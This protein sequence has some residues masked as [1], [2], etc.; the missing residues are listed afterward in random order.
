[1]QRVLIVFILL[2]ILSLKSKTQEKN[3]IIQFNGSAS[4]TD[5]FYSS[6]GIDPR[7]PSNILMTILRANIT[8]FGQIELPFELY[9]SNQRIKFQ[10][11]FNQF[12]ISPKISNWLTLHAGYF[13]TQF[14][15]LSYGD[16]RMLG[17]GIE[18]TPGKFRF[19]AIYGRSQIAI[20]PNREILMPGV[21]R[22]T[23]YGTSIG[24][25]DET[26]TFF[27]INIFHA[28]DDTTSLKQ[29]SLLI[30]P[31]ENIVGTIN[32][33][34]K[35]VSQFS[36]KGEFAMSAFSS[37]IYS[38]KIEEI[39]LPSFLYTPNISS[40]I[41]GAA[42]INF[43]IVPSNFWSITLSSQWVGP[44]Y[45]TLGFAL[46]PN[47][48]M[49]FA[50]A[51]NFKL[52]KN[53]L[54]IKTKAGIRYNN[55]R[56]NRLSTTSRFTGS[57]SVNWQINKNTGLDINYSNNQIQSGHKNDTLKLSNIFN[58]INI[59]PRY[60]F[61]GMGGTNNINLTYT[62][63][64]VAD[65]NVYTSLTNNNKSNTLSINHC[66]FFKSSW[67]FTTTILYTN[68][69]TGNIKIRVF[70]LSETI[71]KNF[72]NNKLTTSLNIGTN[73]VTTTEKNRQLVFRLITIYSLGKLGTINF[74]ISNNNFNGT[75][76]YI[77]SYNEIYGSLQYNIN[78]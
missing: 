9:L 16:L 24:Y 78:F 33:G 18:L 45:T 3:K 58:S 69:S 65:K 53:K 57:L 44:G 6:H 20:K 25:G 40:R 60:T 31:A 17:G 77:K 46:M 37:N 23:A 61:K 76:E 47:D 49:E 36:I 32:F 75:S 62:Y 28:I 7:Q 51:P 63:Q 30:N 22:Q 54:N 14:S 8:L 52:L 26:K 72:A 39:N 56:K 68:I 43:Y 70:H 12:G 10:Q 59:S 41:D 1:M 34:I 74:N 38:Q 27:N 35:I 48:F 73:F 67:S 55:I 2:V 64:D 13:S 42:K 66:I 4:I 11:P 15:E 19:K 21:F 50:L 5:N 29:D 71:S